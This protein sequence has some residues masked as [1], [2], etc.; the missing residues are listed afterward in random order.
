MAEN[1]AIRSVL[2]LITMLVSY[3]VMSALANAIVAFLKIVP[4]G[5]RDGW[6]ALRG[7]CAIQT[8]AYEKLSDKD[9]KKL[10]AELQRCAARAPRAARL[11]LWRRVA[12]DG[13]RRATAPRTGR[14]SR[15]SFRSPVRAARCVSPPPDA[16]P[17]CSLSFRACSRPLMC[18]TRAASD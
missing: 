7:A 9:A 18:F 4:A 10:A 15:S 1:I 12:A 2:S 6:N 8:Y 11:G 13:A 14:T 3:V 5:L 17:Q 16:P